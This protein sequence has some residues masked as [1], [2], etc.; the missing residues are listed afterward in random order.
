[1]DTPLVLFAFIAV[2][3]ISMMMFFNAEVTGQPI[4]IDKIS[5]EMIKKVQKSIKEKEQYYPPAGPVC[6]CPNYGGKILTVDEA[7]VGM[8]GLSFFDCMLVQELIQV[9]KKTK[10][11]TQNLEQWEKYCK[12]SFPYLS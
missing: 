3:A 6:D 11:S 7:P 8:E 10:M 2:V 9:R 12:L 1:M 5:P 4:S